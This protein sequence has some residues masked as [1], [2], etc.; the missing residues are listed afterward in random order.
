VP[1]LKGL[2]TIVDVTQKS[3]AI[4]ATAFP[5]TPA[6]FFWAATP[7][8]GFSGQIYWTVQF[9]TGLSDG[10]TSA[11]SFTNYVRCVR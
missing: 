3:P 4:D 9:D 7:T 6:D 10:T 2:M 11:V 8:L 1:S 5:A